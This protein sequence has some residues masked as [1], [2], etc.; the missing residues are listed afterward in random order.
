MTLIVRSNANWAQSHA[1]TGKTPFFLFSVAIAYFANW[2]IWLYYVLNWHHAA[3]AAM[4]N[5]HALK[6]S[7][8]SSYIE[9]LHSMNITIWFFLIHENT[10]Q[11]GLLSTNPVVIRCF[12]CHAVDSPGIVHA[13]TKLYI[14]RTHG[15]GQIAITLQES[16]VFMRHLIC[17]SS[18]GPELF[19]IHCS[20]Q[21]NYYHIIHD[22][23]CIKCIWYKKWS[24]YKT[25]NTC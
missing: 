16:M 19:L 8:L 10:Q 21:I 20:S 4:N 9:V 22:V 7:W 24:S 18:H 1:H 13:K 25:N 6:K 3:Y 12:T 11:K 2:T 23:N 14:N 5:G 15:H 17:F